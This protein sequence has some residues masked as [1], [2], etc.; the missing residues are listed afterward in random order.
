MTTTVNTNE[1]HN[2]IVNIVREYLGP[3]AERFVD[4]QI[5]FHLNKNP[6]EIT[7]QD[8]SVLVSW[9]GVSIGVLTGDN[10]QVANCVARI[11][12]LAN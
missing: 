10:T 12:S 4:R 2:K 6:E 8:I 7:K 5:T 9:I 3:A 11:N 1:L